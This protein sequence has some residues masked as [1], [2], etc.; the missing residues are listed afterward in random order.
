MNKCSFWC[1]FLYFNNIF[2]S[3]YDY[4]REFLKKRRQNYLKLYF[5]GKVI[6]M[7]VYDRTSRRYHLLY[8][9]DN[10]LKL[11]WSHALGVEY[12]D[13][14]DLP[15]VGAHT[16]LICTCV[17]GDEIVEVALEPGMSFRQLME[18]SSRPDLLYCTL[19]NNDGCHD[20]T[21]VMLPF[22]S[23]LQ[24]NKTVD[25]KAFV[26]AVCHYKDK[27]LPWDETSMLKLMTDDDFEEKIFKDNDIIHI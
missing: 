9:T 1:W 10:V 2:I 25:T 27:V 24:V 16:L 8:D 23:S 4:F 21:K 5:D 14:W 3:F 22:K 19:V 17:V 18:K 26:D 15:C 13:F 20:I 11:M 6:K 12:Y 7:A